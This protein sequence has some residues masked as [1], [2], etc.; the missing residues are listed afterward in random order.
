MTSIFYL[1]KD[2]NDNYLF[3]DHI[4]SY[5]PSIK[6]MVEIE[7]NCSLPFLDVLIDKE[8]INFVCWSI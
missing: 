5:H 1:S 7:D 8:G 2:K 6:S 3:L 4:R